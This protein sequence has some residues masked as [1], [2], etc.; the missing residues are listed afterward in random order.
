MTKIVLPYS[1]TSLVRP[2]VL[3]PVSGMGRLVGVWP[4]PQEVD[5]FP[6]RLAS[7]QPL[8]I[9][10]SEAVEHSHSKAFGKRESRR[11]CELLQGTY[12][13]TRPARLRLVRRTF[14]Q[15]LVVLPD[16]RPISP[17]LCPGTNPV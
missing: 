11:S 5:P 2:A 12:S 4:A 9:S 6:K 16:A 15:Q 13:S 17:R 3:Q 8:A 14:L 10:L 1:A 7:K